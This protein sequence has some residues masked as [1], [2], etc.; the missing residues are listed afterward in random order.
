MAMLTMDYHAD[1]L[2]LSRKAGQLRAPKARL[3]RKQQVEATK[4]MLAYDLGR[5]FGAARSPGFQSPIL[6]T[7]A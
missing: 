1:E 3:R 6:S 5:R 4:L 2:L 7:S